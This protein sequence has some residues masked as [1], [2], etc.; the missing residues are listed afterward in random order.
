LLRFLSIPVAG[1]GSYSSGY[2]HSKWQLLALSWD[3]DPPSTNGSN[4]LRAVVQTF[5][6][7]FFGQQKCPSSEAATNR[8]FPYVNLG[9]L[10]SKFRPDADFWAY[11]LEGCPQ[12][13]P[14]ICNA[15]FNFW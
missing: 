1:T 5:F 13:I 7:E 12:V 15:A 4:V 6:T 2:A 8:T 14:V 11:S 10:N 9:I 3:F